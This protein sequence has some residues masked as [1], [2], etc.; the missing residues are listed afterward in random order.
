MNC[1][2]IDEY[3]GGEPRRNGTST[4]D[5]N[6]HSPHLVSPIDQ[7]VV[8]GSPLPQMAVFLAVKVVLLQ[9]VVG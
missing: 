3:C 2:T 9:P 6:P 4:S 7:P 8:V 1:V 5:G